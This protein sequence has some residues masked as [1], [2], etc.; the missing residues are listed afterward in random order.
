MDGEVDADGPPSPEEL[1]AMCC[2][3]PFAFTVGGELYR[4]LVR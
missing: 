2:D 4:F 3:G 1:A